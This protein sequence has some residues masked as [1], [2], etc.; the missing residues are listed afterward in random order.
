MMEELSRRERRKAL[1]A[2]QQESREVKQK[3]GNFVKWLVA[4][5]LIAG[6]LF[7]VWWFWREISKPLPGQQF[8]D[9]GR[10]H[11]TDISNI[12]YNSSPPTSGAHFPVWAKKGIYDRVI[13]DGYLIHSLE[14]GYVV[15]SYDCSQ[16][17]KLKSQSSK[18][19]LKTQNFLTVYAHETGESHE[20]TSTPSAE[21]ASSA[22]PLT[23]MMVGVTGTMSFFGPSNAPAAEVELPG[24]FDSNECKKLVA[25]LRNIG[26]N[27]ERVII[28]PR[29]GM[30]ERI[31][32]TAWTRLDVLD[33]FDRER[34]KN[35]IEA[36]QNKGPEKTVE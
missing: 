33:S 36:Y 16:N 1:K 17:L 3:T 31:A 20:E 34:V 30:E 8:A 5:L 22:K 19:Q 7:V 21:A 27:Y 23:K 2:E 14:H 24:E 28:V 13:S 35:F 4:L 6:V 26:D 32:L 15:I 11:V 10:D 25:D 12:S 29:P 9:L 18:L